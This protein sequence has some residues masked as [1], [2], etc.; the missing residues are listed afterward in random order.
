MR[1]PFN[2]VMRLSGVMEFSQ[3]AHITGKYDHETQKPEKL[4]RA[5]ILTCSRENDLVVVPFVGSGTECAMAVRENRQYVGFEINPKHCATATA[6]I[7][8][9]IEARRQQ[10]MFAPE[11]SNGKSHGEMIEL[12]F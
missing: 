7:K 4:T 8:K 5:L 9:E 1:R 12:A 6:R 2:N 11:K 10:N 3:E